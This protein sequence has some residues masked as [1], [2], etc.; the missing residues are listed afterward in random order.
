MQWGIGALFSVYGLVIG[1]FLAVCIERLPHGE[2][3]RGRSHCPVCGKK[4]GWKDLIPLVSFL[5][6]GGRCRY[7]GAKISW[8]YLLI[9]GG[10]ALLFAV[11]GYRFGFSRQA[12]VWCAVFSVLIIISGLDWLT[13]EINDEWNGLLMGLGVLVVWLEGDYTWQQALLGAGIVSVPLAV[14]AWVTGG[15][16]GGDVKMMAALG[17]VLGP[18]LVVLD[19][20]IGCV[21]A[22]VVSVGLMILGKVHRHSAIAWGPFLA[23]G[24]AVAILVG[25]TMVDW[26]LNLLRV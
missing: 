17:V 22:A 24:A 2:S 20:F 5:A 26:Y 11:C 15:I 12:V 10:T 3:V 14:V 19:F 13:G 6:L 25:D 4:L 16:G 1:S 9:E 7:C 18:R 8:R 23:L 21:S